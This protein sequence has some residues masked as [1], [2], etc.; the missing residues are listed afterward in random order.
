MNTKRIVLAGGSGFLGQALAAHFSKA[1]WEVVILTRQPDQIGKEARGVFWDAG[2]LGSWQ[3]ELEGASALVNLTGKSV[4]CRYDKRNRE[5]IL[6]SRLCSTRV[7][8]EA[9]TRC[10]RPPAVWLNASTATIYRHTFDSAWG[11]N[12]Q[13]G[14][15]KEA[16]DRFSIEV[17]TAWEE[18]FNQA[19]TPHTRKVALRTA[20]VLGFAKNSVF[21][22]L[23]RLVRLGQGGK[24]GNG[25]QFVSWIHEQD[26]CRAI[27]WLVNRQDIS[28]PVNLAAPNPIPNREMMS[29]LRGVCHVP[30]G[31]PASEWMLELGAF[32][33]RTEAELIIKSRRVVPRRLLDSGFTF[34]FPSIR[35]AFEDLCQNPVPS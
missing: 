8:G 9:I 34:H 32:F 6:N 14:A 4:N 30:I 12:G 33:L 21:P 10:N 18:V 11:E 25:R 23:R 13:I 5:E 22:V 29:I 17:A 35:E 28:G 27:E 19:P 26:F 2:S 16:K 15:A 3:K 1:G 7:L 20:M 24:M 31:L